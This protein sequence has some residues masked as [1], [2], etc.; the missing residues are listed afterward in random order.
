MA[1]NYDSRPNKKLRAKET[2]DQLQS[3]LNLSREEIWGLIKQ[4]SQANGLT[5][6]GDSRTVLTEDFDHSRHPLVDMMARSYVA[7]AN[8]IR[9]MRLDRRTFK[10]K[11]KKIWLEKKYS[12]FF[13]KV[14]TATARRSINSAWTSV[15]PEYSLNE[16]R[17]PP[18]HHD[19]SGRFKATWQYAVTMSRVGEDAILR[20]VKYYDGLIVHAEPVGRIRNCDIFRC[21][22]DPFNKNVDP[23]TTALAVTREH[24]AIGVGLNDHHK[25]AA[26]AAEKN[27]RDQVKSLLGV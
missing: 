13:S 23:Y 3:L 20:A 1:S 15:V 4:Y 24:D 21:V 6:N 14:A 17:R 7:E 22:F 5:Y 9:N 26:S 25:R 19:G 8:H 12:R 11:S 2:M 18:V 10:L 16:D 27:L